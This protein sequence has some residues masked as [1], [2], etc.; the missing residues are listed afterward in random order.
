M[1]IGI[2]LYSHPSEPTP[3]I[4]GINFYGLTVSSS[5][6]QDIDGGTCAY[7]GCL[8][9]RETAQ[10]RLRCKEDGKTHRPIVPAG[11]QPKSRPLICRSNI[12]EALGWLVG[13]LVGGKEVP[14]VRRTPN[15]SGVHERHEK[16]GGG[17][18]GGREGGWIEY[19]V[20][21]EKY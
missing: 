2:L 20:P 15:Q 5:H 16:E 14:G 4:I 6:T 21:V 7:M 3:F 12:R 11:R 8:R 1:D 9:N 10:K 17:G 18:G 19:T 13:W